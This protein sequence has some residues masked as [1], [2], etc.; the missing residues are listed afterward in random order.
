MKKSRLLNT[1]KRIP[2]RLDEV[3]VQNHYRRV[4]IR[5]RKYSSRLVNMGFVFD[6]HDD[7]FSRGQNRVTLEYI[8]EICDFT[9]EE[10]KTKYKL[11]V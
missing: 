8:Q 1:Y 7:I 3:G 4:A 10:F 9:D 11:G 5:I 2:H 6:K